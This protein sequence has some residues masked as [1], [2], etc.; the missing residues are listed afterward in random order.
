MLGRLM[1]HEFRATGRFALPLCGVMMA[2]AVLAGTAQR[3]L[4]A[5]DSSPVGI[6]V[7]VLYGLSVFAVAIGIFIILMQH[8][9]RNLLGDEG[10][11]MLT[12]PVSVHELLL[13]KL[14]VALIWYVAALALM[15]L[16]ALLVLTISGEASADGLRELFAELRRA[17]ASDPGLIVRSVLLYF[18]VMGLLTLLFYADFTISQSFSRHKVLCNIAGVVILLLLSWLFNWL[19]NVTGIYAVT[20]NGAAVNGPRVIVEMYVFDAALYALTFWFL[21]RRPN[22]E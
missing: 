13:S 2:L 17:M 11:L 18:G 14:L 22:I 6:T 20:E 5:A 7:F 3:S 15:L 12:L 16:S 8:F 9:K 21:R 19:H 1:K 4:S 10:Y